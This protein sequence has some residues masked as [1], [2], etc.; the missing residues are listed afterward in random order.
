MKE[1][2]RQQAHEREE[3]D[4]TPRE[5]DPMV[6][7][8]WSQQRSGFVCPFSLDQVR[9]VPARVGRALPVDDA[10]SGAPASADEEEGLDGAGWRCPP[11]VDAGV[12][13]VEAAGSR[14][15]ARARRTRRRAPSS[16]RR[17]AARYGKVSGELER[18]RVAGLR[19]PNDP[20]LGGVRSGFMANRSSV[21]ASSAGLRFASTGSELSVQLDDGDGSGPTSSSRRHV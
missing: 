4:P 16:P 15:A 20:R 14:T 12:S 2:A 11:S 5:E 21:S 18:G 10:R 9:Q 3:H 19:A 1:T 6:R 17:S 7:T 8:P 13:E